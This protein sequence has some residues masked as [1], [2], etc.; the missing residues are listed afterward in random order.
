MQLGK[1]LR[2]LKGNRVCSST[3]ATMPGQPNIH[4]NFKCSHFISSPKQVN[5]LHPTVLV[6]V[7]DG[8]VSTARGPMANGKIMGVQFGT[9]ACQCFAL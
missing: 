7:H 4:V 1:E 3:C 5:C 9:R 2:G 6:D 8:C